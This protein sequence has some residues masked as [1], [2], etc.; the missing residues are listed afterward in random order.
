MDNSEER[1]RVKSISHERTVTLA[2]LAQ[3]NTANDAWIAIK[4]R[5]YNITPYMKGHPGGP[6]Q[7]MRGAGTDATQLF[8]EVHSY[9]NHDS[10]LKKYT[11]GRLVKD[12]D[13]ASPDTETNM[14]PSRPPDPKDFM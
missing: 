14:Q 9:V 13:D 11:I 10:I 5:V 7:L 4:G 12:S 3:H 2:E 1:E 6:E 8:N